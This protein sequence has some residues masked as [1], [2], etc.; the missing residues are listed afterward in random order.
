ME[1]K[2]EHKTYKYLFLDR[3]GVIN[4]ERP[5]D[6]AKNVDEFVFIP[7][8]IEAI[9]HLTPLFDRIFIITNQRGIGRNIFSENDLSKVHQY[10]LQKINEAGGK[11]DQIYYCT[12]ISD[13]SINR[14]P[15]IG[16]AFQAQRDFPEI[17]FSKSIFVGN[18][19]SDIQF[20]N[21]LGMFTVL[22]GDKYEQSHIIYKIINAFHENLAKFAD[23]IIVSQLKTDK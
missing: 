11:I 14:K 5:K 18:S 19:K 22:V 15:N 3:D 17:D 23:S 12:D 4:V 21:K 10:M 6:Y 8:A 9:A 7:N 13:S 20:G 1:K 2:T 16:M